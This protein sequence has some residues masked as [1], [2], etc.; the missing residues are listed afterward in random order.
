M[1][2]YAW[3]RVAAVLSVL[4]LIQVSVVPPCHSA[5]IGAVARTTTA[6]VKIAASTAAAAKPAQTGLRH[7][8]HN[9]AAAVPYNGVVF[10]TVVRCLHPVS[11]NTT[12]SWQTNNQT[13]SFVFEN[14]LP[15]PLVAHVCNDFECTE[16]NSCDR[17]MPAN[18]ITT[19]VMPF[20]WINLIVSVCPAA[21]AQNS[22]CVWQKQPYK[23]FG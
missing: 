4:A 3:L 12:H 15:N 10:G 11:G 8:Q 20:K 1:Q 2:T 6:P 13:A 7:H 16:R 19:I 22:T 17:A 18:G 5:R 14:G 21:T 9:G 23:K